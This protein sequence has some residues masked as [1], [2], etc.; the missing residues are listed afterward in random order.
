MEAAAAV[1][2]PDYV[3]SFQLD[4]Y[5]LRLEYSA[6]QRPGVSASAGSHAAGASDSG[7]FSRSAGVMDWVCDRCSTTN[8]ARC[9]WP[10]GRGS[11]CIGLLMSL[12]PAARE[13]L[14]QFV[15][16][17]SSVWPKAV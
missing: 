11:I 9:E 12:N 3:D 4:G 5:S 13:S 17:A 16:C 14:G 8:F 2:A 7:G 6:S 1:M 10:C 15:D